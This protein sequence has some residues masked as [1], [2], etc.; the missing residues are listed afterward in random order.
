M[1]ALIFYSDRALLVLILL[2]VLGG[3]AS[4]VDALNNSSSTNNTSDLNNATCMASEPCELELGIAFG[5]PWFRAKSGEVD[6]FQVCDAI[7]VESSMASVMPSI[8]PQCFHKFSRGKKDSQKVTTDG[9][10]E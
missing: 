4:N 10:F 8:Q 5:D 9:C 3:W 2:Y 6:F 7:W 1:K